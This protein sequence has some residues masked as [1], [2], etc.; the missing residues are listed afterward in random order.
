MGRD[1]DFNNLFPYPFLKPDMAAPLPDNYKTSA[2]EGIYYDAIG[3]V[4]YPGQTTTS[5]TVLSALLKIS[6]SAGSR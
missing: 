4:G 5:L 1:S 3:K 6:S 2:L